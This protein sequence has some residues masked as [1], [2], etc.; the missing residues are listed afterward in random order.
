MCQDGVYEPQY[1]QLLTG[2]KQRILLQCKENYTPKLGLMFRPTVTHTNNSPFVGI[3]N[4]PVSEFLRLS[5]NKQTSR[6]V[7]NEKLYFH[8]CGMYSFYTNT[9]HLVQSAGSKIQT[10]YAIRR[11]RPSNRLPTIIELNKY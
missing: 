10:K 5:Q 4:L 8:S 11:D 1:S 6:I 7:N 2:F 3:E 9:R